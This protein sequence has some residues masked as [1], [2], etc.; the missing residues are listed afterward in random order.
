VAV[1]GGLDDEIANA[2]WSKKDLGCDYNGNTTVIVK[3]ES[4][5]NFPQPT[6]EVKFERPDS[7]PIKYEV[8]IVDDPTLPSNI[9]Q[10]IKDAIIARF[11]GAD[12]TNRERIGSSIFA[13]RY[14]APVSAVSTSV[15]VISIYIGTVTPT[16][17]KVDVGIDQ[18]PTLTAADITVNLI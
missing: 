12:G 15:A 17:T 4:G 16:L 18:S 8:N 10:L 11:N 9:V 13:S 1:V 7:L 3:D 14:Y 2:I 5:Y 6:Y